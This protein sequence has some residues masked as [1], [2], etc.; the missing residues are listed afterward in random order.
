MALQTRRAPMTTIGGMLVTVA[1]CYAALCAAMYVLQERML[2]LPNIP[3]REI[4]AT[5]AAAGLAYE[6]TTLTAADGVRLHA[7]WVPAAGARWTL[8]HFHGN[9]GNISHRLEL[10]QIFHALGANVLL[11]DYRGYGRSEGAPSEEG[12]Q[13]DAEAAWDHL[14]RT[15]GLPPQGIVIHGQSM[16]AAVAAWLAAR[17]PPAGLVLESAFTSVPDLAAELYPWLPARRLARLRLD[18]RSE[19]SRV[20]CPVLLIHSRQ[21]EI[22]PFAHGQALLDAAREPKALLAIQG[23]HNGGFWISRE[24]YAA[25]IAAFLATLPR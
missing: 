22:I 15:R 6:E 3:G 7:W 23:D 10:L 12:L 14:T 20:A 8:V 2:F 5:P 9:A 11:F 21:D 4:D 1:A 24:A 25:G 13:R 18:T 16:G 17:R 19:L